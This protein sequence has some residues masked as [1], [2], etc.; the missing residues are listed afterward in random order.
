MGKLI[1]FALLATLLLATH[2]N[3]SPVSFDKNPPP[4]VKSASTDG[5]GDVG[6]A[7][8]D[9][10]GS[11]VPV[12][13]LPD[14]DTVT[15]VIVCDPFSASSGCSLGS[16][17]RGNIYYFNGDE[18]DIMSKKVDDYINFGYRTN[19]T[20]IMNTFDIPTRSFDQGFPLS[21]GGYIQRDD[22]QQLVEWFAIDVKGLIN[23]KNA[24]LAGSYQLAVYSDDGSI[25]VVDGS[26]AINNDGAHSSSWKCATSPLSLAHNQPHT[27]RL[28]YFQGPRTQIALRLLWRPWA[29]S[30]QAC[31]DSGGFSPI[32][33][34]VLFPN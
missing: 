2:Q 24:A 33:A 11:S 12:G 27:I 17:L 25:L 23:V 3:C 28:K 14:D 5:D 20:L 26:E 10:G 16:G 22:G 21:G 31:N 29:Q 4:P 19:Y 34:E 15:S 8:T 13:G 1:V 18:A 7:V 32:P 9:G 30:G 6:G